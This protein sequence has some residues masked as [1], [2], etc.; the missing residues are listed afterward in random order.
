MPDKLT[1]KNRWSI[2]LNYQYL[3]Q[4]DREVPYLKNKY[5][6]LLYLY[7]YKKG[8][9]LKYYS[10]ANKVPYINVNLYLSENLADVKPNRRPY[11]VVDLM[12]LLGDTEDDILCLDYFEILF[13][14]SLMLQ[15]FDI[16]KNLSKRKVV[17]VAWR[18]E[19]KDGYLIHAKPGHPEY[20][21]EL[22]A[23]TTIIY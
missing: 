2:L 21:K 15:A 14:P 9:T 8:D 16:F 7:E 6:K 5:H 10:E 1:L 17:L 11:K 20:T 19:I 3:N 12:N 4:L 18:D 22:I 13:E 23:D